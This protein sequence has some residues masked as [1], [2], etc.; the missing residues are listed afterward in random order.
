VFFAADFF[1]DNY[2]T[3]FDGS[4]PLYFTTKY[5][6][7]KS[8]TPLAIGAEARLIE[9]EAAMRAGDAATFLTKL[10]QA[11]AAAPTYAADPDVTSPPRPKPAPLTAAQIPAT[12]AGQV[13][14][15]FQERALALFLTGHRVGDLRRLTYQYGRPPESVWPTGPYQETNP[16]KQG[17]N[18]GP[19]VNL[20]IPQEEQNNPQFIGQCINRSA[21]IK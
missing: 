19:D 15:L 12:L 14:L 3:G 21:D 10:N 17:T 2:A 11:R 16:D 9:A 7:Y 6:D 20:P 8:A 1:G 4:T 5:S 13:D 18:Y